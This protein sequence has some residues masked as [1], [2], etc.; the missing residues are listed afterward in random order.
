M[1]KASSPSSVLRGRPEPRL[2]TPPARRLTRRTTRGYEVCDFAD[3]IGEP[4]LPWQA[5]LVKH[6][7]ELN[8]DGT[9]RFRVVLCLVARQNGKTHALRTVSLWR[10]YMDGARLVLGAAQSADIAREAWQACVDTA[11]S[12]PDLA[13][14]VANVRFANGEQSLALESGARYRITAATRSAGRGLSVDQLNL[15]EVR[16]W[17]SWEP[18]S[19]LSKTTMA[20]ANGQCWAISNQGDDESVVLNHLREAALSGRDPSIFLAEWSAPDG[21]DLDDPEAWCQANP[22]LGHTISEQ[23]IRTSLATD[24]PAVFRT[25]VLCMRVSSLD[26]AVSMGAW[27]DCHDPAGSLESLRQRVVCAVDVAPDG[28][29]VSLVAAA[30]GSDGRVRI[31]VVA[32]WDSTNV[33]RAQLPELLERVKPRAVAWYPGGPAAALTSALRGLPRV[34]E[35]KGAAVAET[36]QEFADL[37]AARRVVHPGDP[38]LTS[39]VAGAQRLHQGDGWRFVRRG[40]GHVDGVYAAAAAARLALTLPAVGKPR[41]IVAG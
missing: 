31:E 25:E 29:H 13:A 1:V 39:H 6:A 23:A 14:E 11:R 17:R 2:F 5:W 35:I 41:L 34:V 26:E 3:M 38:L 37:V 36:C 16:E 21:C 32:A 40:A 4:L 15:D 27:R 8:P 7:L 30:L 22:G 19:A 12:V 9:F 33:A 10:M 20:R 24:P 28:A 18:W